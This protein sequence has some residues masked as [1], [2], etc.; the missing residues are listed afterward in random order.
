MF[1]RQAALQYELFT[2][3]GAPIEVMRDVLRQGISAVRT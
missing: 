2:G 1:V 3:R